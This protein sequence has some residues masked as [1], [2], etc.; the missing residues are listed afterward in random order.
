MVKEIK[1]INKNITFERL[2]GENRYDTAGIISAKLSS[3]TA[4][5]AYGH[6]FP[7]AL[8]IAPY[9]AK[10]GYPV[11]LTGIDG[12]LA[13]E[14][15]AKISGFDKV[16]VVGGKDVVS[17]NAV[18]GLDYK[19]Y[20][21]EDRY[22][23]NLDINKNLKMGNNLA[24]LATGS[25]FLTLFLEQFSQQRKMHHFSYHLSRAGQ[26]LTEDTVTLLKEQSFDQFGLF[27]GKDVLDVEEDLL[28]V[29][30]SR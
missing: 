21:G 4:V 11:F 18:Q 2:G 27:G 1:T 14:T 17:D 23:T 19:R 20:S 6:K 28:D 24:Y 29:I 8:S 16:I 13:K 3:D 25:N 9:A 15:K 10:N 26:D 12:E 7:D 5:L 22:K 30:L